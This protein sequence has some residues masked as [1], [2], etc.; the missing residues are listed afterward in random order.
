[1]DPPVPVGKP[2]GKW[3]PDKNW[4]PR[5]SL[6][7]VWNPRGGI[8]PIF[9]L[10]CLAKVLTEFSTGK[11]CCAKG[12]AEQFPETFWGQVELIG[13]I[14]G[15]LSIL[16]AC[17]HPAAKKFPEFLLETSECFELEQGPFFV[18]PVHDQVL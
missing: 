14:G 7:L 18:D 6:S 4:P 9:G 12:S 11:D 10:C 5:G 16:Y 2:R 1:M 3:C 8:R 13:V 15:V 17:Y